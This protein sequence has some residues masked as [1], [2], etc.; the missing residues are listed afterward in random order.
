MLHRFKRAYPK[1]TVDRDSGTWAEVVETLGSIRSMAGL[2]GD[3]AQLD[4]PSA[5]HVRALTDLFLAEAARFGRRDLEAAETYYREALALFRVDQDFWNIAWALYHLANM[6]GE[7]GDY[8]AIPALCE[9][10]LALGM[11]GSDFEI[12]ALNHR[13]LGDAALAN[14]DV[15]GCLKNY[16]KAVEYAYRFQVDPAE[17]DD[18]TIQFY[19]DIAERV[20]QKLLA[21]ACGDPDLAQEIAAGLR[22]GWLDC[23]VPLATP[24]DAGAPLVTAD[25]KTLCPQLF[26]AA[27]ATERRVADG[28]AY[29]KAV[30][31]HLSRLNQRDAGGTLPSGS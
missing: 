28:E 4:R 1:E 13:L 8:S 29:G 17:P 19:A 5:R 16:R 25:A 23:G 18:Y 7:S 20:C 6:L 21:R 22:Q 2:D 27:L 11:T 3:V 12:V 15:A 10:S 9:E 26:P 30:R 24:D 31:D 14:G